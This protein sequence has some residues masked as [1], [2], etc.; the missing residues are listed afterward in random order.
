M[1]GQ[2]DRFVSILDL[3]KS[4]TLPDGTRPI[5]LG[6]GS[7]A[8]L[9]GTG[10]MSNVYKIWNPQ[11]ER[12]RAVKLMKPDLSAESRQR[13]QTEIKITAALSHP[14][15]I[16]IHSVGEWNS[17]SYIE[18]E[19]I[20]GYTLSE[21]L[22]KRG[23]FPI[24]VCTAIAVM[25]A[26]ALAYAHS[27]EY[28]IYGKTHH[29]VIHRDLKPS[30]IMLAREG[31]VKLM[32]FGIARPV[33]SSLMT[34]DGAVMGTM[35]YLAPEQ[36]DGKNVGVTA[37]IY[38]IG[39]MLYEMLTG[40]KAFPQ[41]NLAQLME[42]KT[43]NYFVPLKHFKVQIPGRLKRLVGRCMMHDAAKRIQTADE[44]LKELE[45]FHAKVTTE[46]PDEVLKRFL[47]SATDAGQAIVI[48][49]RSLLPRYAAVAVAGL[50]IVVAAIALWS[51]KAKRIMPAA[52]KPPVASVAAV[53]PG[54]SNVKHTVSP[55][56]GAAIATHPSI[57][58]KHSLG[59]TAVPTPK[60][61]VRDEAHERVLAKQP[62]EPISYLDSM[63]TVNGIDDPVQ[64]MV[65]EA[66]AGR[67]KN[68]LRLFADLPLPLAANRYAQLLR[69]R[70]LLRVGKLKEADEIVR[71]TTID[72]GEFYLIKSQVI[73]ENGD[74]DRALATI[75]KSVGVPAHFFEGEALRRE[76]FYCK[77][78]CLSRLFDRSP[79]EENRKSALDS[80][81][82]VK[83]AMRTFPDH[84]YY[85]KAVSEMQRIGTEGLKTNG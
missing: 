30:N 48:P 47:P 18:M 3:Q 1:D 71:T 49:T 54:D 22:A 82:E 68:V 63:K 62:R 79:S 20:D 65:D 55:A 66:G 61:P 7:I 81:F 51:K 56:G 33:D 8:E 21:I 36:I 25:V 38:A 64:L 84:A 4:V 39:A 74:P 46:N 69:L 41:V 75:E 24:P 76:Y 52:A 28:V 12:F 44:L 45:F 26:R 19:Y 43:R 53:R 70:A 60:L 42:A 83:N 59:N 14:N 57:D 72:D 11:M 58:V 34:H 2:L 77:A 80:W 13:F 35:Q 32:D 10:G 37:D 23:A 67:F 15:I 9:I 16:E 5:E 31:R 73:L 50:L 29:G 40:K 27:K 17:L 85:R 78:L 6:S